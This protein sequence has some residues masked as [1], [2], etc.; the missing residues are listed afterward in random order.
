ME[1]DH[2]R[3]L[4][5]P[6][7]V[8]YTGSMSTVPRIQIDGSGGSVEN[9]SDEG[10]DDWHSATSTTSIL[11]ASDVRS[12]RAH[13]QRTV[14]RLIVSTN[15]VRYVRS[16]PKKEMWRKDFLDLVELRKVEV[17]KLF[18]ITFKSSENLEFEFIDGTELITG[19]KER[20]EAFNMIIAFS[21]LQWQSLQI[22]N[23]TNAQP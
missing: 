4:T 23:N 12:F 14:G 15:G 5:K 16:L 17:S 11:D 3:E 21:G 20:D 9:C 18:K 19:I 13:W 22:R 7:I 6:A 1:E 2:F 10:D 8:E